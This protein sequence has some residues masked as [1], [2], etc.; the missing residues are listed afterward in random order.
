[1]LC[2]MRL[3]KSDTWYLDIMVIDTLEIPE[4]IY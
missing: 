2:L 3:A 1:M 4:E